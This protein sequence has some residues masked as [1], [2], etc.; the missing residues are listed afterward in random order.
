ML[1]IVEGLSA[2]RN[3]EDARALAREA[4]KGYLWSKKNLRSVPWQAY[5]VIGI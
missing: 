4:A 5:A 1:T 2:G 3:G